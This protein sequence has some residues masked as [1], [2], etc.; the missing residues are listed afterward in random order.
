MITL[1]ARGDRNFAQTLKSRAA[2]A[3]MP[4]AD[5]VREK[6]DYAIAN[7]ES[8]F[9]ASRGSDVNRNGND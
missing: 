8:I 6:L 4:L 5:Y 7:D 1:Y 3:G 2:L 9:F